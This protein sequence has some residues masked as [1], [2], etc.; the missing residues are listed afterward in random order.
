[1]FVYKRYIELD[2][3]NILLHQILQEIVLMWL[4]RHES[5]LMSGRQKNI[6]N[7]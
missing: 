3:S 1:M 5:S 7:P 6:S 4:D 2:L